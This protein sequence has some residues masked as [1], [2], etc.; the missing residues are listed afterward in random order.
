MY[1]VPAKYKKQIVQELKTFVPLIN[2]LISRSKSSSEED[3][4][5]LLND[6]LHS[7]LGYNKLN[8]LKTEMRDKS[9]RFDY[10]VKLTD[11]PIKGKADKLD[12]IIEAK[13]CHVELN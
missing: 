13:A 9:N 1:K 4:R 8:E 5:I 7:V 10:G 12:F 2:A 3:A 6:M 11:S